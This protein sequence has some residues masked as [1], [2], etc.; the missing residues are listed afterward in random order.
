MEKQ[1]LNEIQ[2][3]VPG[4]P[5]YFEYGTLVLPGVADWEM[6]FICEAIAAS[7]QARFEVTQQAHGYNVVFALS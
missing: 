4:V 3:T 7:T 6:P 2:E 1:I 5:A